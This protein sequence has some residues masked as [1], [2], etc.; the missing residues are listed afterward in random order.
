[1]KIFKLAYRTDNLAHGLLGPSELG[2]DLLVRAGG[3]HG[4]CPCVHRDLMT[5]SILVLEHLWP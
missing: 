5:G 3:Q 1:M 2:N 4:V